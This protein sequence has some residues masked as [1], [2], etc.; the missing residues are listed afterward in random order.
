MHLQWESVIV[1]W[2]FMQTCILKLNLIN[3]V[4]GW[5]LLWRPNAFYGAFKLLGGGVPPRMPN[6]IPECMNW[7]FFKNF[8]LILFC[9]YLTQPIS[10]LLSYQVS[11][12]SGHGKSAPITWF[13]EGKKGEESGEKEMEN[14]KATWKY[15]IST[16]PPE[17]YPHS[18]D[19]LYTIP[20]P[21][22][23]MPTSPPLHTCGPSGTG[24]MLCQHHWL[25]WWQVY[26]YHVTW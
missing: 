9:I 16:P 23:A 2:G 13:K 25:W 18:I 7:Y 10:W 22:T 12:L 21:V 19:P 5:H 24:P 1:S 3:M 6:L 15:I 14:V 4:P 20:I 8:T 11:L 17:P 26:I